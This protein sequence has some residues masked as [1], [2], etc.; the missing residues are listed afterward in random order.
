VSELIADIC[1][2]RAVL[3]QLRC[4]SVSEIVNAKVAQAGAL[5]RRKEIP[6]IHVAVIQDRTG[7]GREDELI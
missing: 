1:Q 7:F 6:G 2:T 4:E 3:Q 5:D